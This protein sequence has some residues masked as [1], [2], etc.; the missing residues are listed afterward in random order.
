M[1]CSINADLTTDRSFVLPRSLPNII[2]HDCYGLQYKTQ[3]DCEVMEVDQRIMDPSIWN[4][5]SRD[6]SVCDLSIQGDSR[7]SL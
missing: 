6:L 3:E 5:S 4:L 1:P 7:L 2:G